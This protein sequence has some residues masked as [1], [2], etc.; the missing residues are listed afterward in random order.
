MVSWLCGDGLLDDNFLFITT[1]DN[2]WCFIL[3]TCYLQK[4]LQ[5]RDHLIKSSVLHSFLVSLLLIVPIVLSTLISLVRATL[6]V[7][8]V[9]TGVFAAGYS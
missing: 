5:A 2:L 3:E 9:S 4:R 7:L 8:F 6:L 1:F